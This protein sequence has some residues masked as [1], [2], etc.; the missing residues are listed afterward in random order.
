MDRTATA[1]NAPSS[2]SII[3]T[4]QGKLR[5]WVDGDVLVFKGI[6]YGEADRF[7]PPRTAASWSGVRDALAFGKSSPQPAP[8]DVSWK[9]WNTER[10]PQS[11]D[12]LALNVYAP[13]DGA[14]R[15]RPVMFYLHGG[16]FTTGSAST[17]GLNGIHL[18]RDGDVVVV[19]INHRLN[20]FGFSCLAELAG[21]DYADSGNVGMMDI[22]TALRWVRDNIAAFG[23]DAG[24]VTIFGQSGGGSKV[25]YLMA[26]KSAKGLFHKAIIQSASSLVRLATAGQATDAARAF[27]KEAGVSADKLKDISIEAMLKARLAVMAKNGGVDISRPVMDGRFFEVHP[28]EPAS[29]ELSRDIPLM[30][31]ATDTEQ[32]YMLGHVESNFTVNRDQATARIA[33]FMD[34]PNEDASKLFDDYISS[35]SNATPG[36]IMIAVLSDQAY[37]RNNS[38]AAERKAALGGAP[39]YSYL[40]QWKTPVLGGRLKSPHIMCVPFVFGTY[41]AAA[42]MLGN[43]PERAPLSKKMM[44]AWTSFARTGVP[45][46]AGLP[47][48]TR[49]DAA[50]RPTMILDN[51][52]RIE[53]DPRK[54]D[55]VAL[56]RYPLYNPANASRRDG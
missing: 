53:N 56:E 17:S 40:L 15:K 51:E 7:M 55:R 9:E 31:G 32:T 24:N 14:A 11:E 46:A 36:E 21:V 2:T 1:A 49:F 29:L 37:R 30:V 35:R 12:C 27:C 42:P 44:G 34:I 22:V 4:A 33:R 38:L 39:V 50:T 25:A 23:G 19:T 3:E 52:C 54:S 43:G 48:W 26:A 16:A 10:G 18:V 5:G 13:V 41:E 20:V 6:P 45:A 28:F 47:A 8:S